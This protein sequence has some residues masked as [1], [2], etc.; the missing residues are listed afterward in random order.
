MAQRFL[1]Q[2]ILPN[3]FYNKNSFSELQSAL[4]AKPRKDRIQDPLKLAR[5]AGL[6]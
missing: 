4:K 6:L 5:D 2:G 1:Q 3:Q